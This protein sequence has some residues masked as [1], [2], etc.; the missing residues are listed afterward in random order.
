MKRSE[1]CRF[2]RGIP[3]GASTLRPPP[4]PIMCHQEQVSTQGPL[5]NCQHPIIASSF[6]FAKHDR[7]ANYPRSSL[8]LS[9]NRGSAMQ[10]LEEPVPRV[11]LRVRMSGQQD[12]L[13]NLVLGLPRVPMSDLPPSQVPMSCSHSPPQPIRFFTR[14]PCSRAGS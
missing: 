8:L 5:R 7:Q 3:P 4:L 1:S 13:N 10:T 12:S 9:R 14:K 6:L 2:L 11:H